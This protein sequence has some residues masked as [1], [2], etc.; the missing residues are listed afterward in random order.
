M[1]PRKLYLLTILALEIILILLLYSTAVGNYQSLH[2]NYNENK[3][4][5]RS[6]F[7]YYHAIE[8]IKWIS[9]FADNAV[10]SSLFYLF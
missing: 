5:K 2:S 1:M 7:C 10:G 8:Q 3:I 9:E 6:R 4:S